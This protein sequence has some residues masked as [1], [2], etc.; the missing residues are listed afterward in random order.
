MIFSPDQHKPLK[1]YI[2]PHTYEDPNIA[3]H[4]FVTEIDPSVIGKQKV[5]GVGEWVFSNLLHS[6]TF[7]NSQIGLSN[8]STCCLT[9]NQESL[10]K[11]FG[12]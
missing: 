4:K 12:V 3:I 9:A 6:F 5:I 2:D 7:M 8:I 10:G 1:T 11:C